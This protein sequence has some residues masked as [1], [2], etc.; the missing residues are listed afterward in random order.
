MDDPKFTQHLKQNI[1]FRSPHLRKNSYLKN[2]YD[3]KY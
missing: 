2:L 3:F 1:N